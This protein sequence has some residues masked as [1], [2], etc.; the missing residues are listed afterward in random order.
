MPKRDQPE[1]RLQCAVADLL[2]LTAMPGVYW[3]ALPF[4]E[5]RTLE[6]GIRL[7][8]MGVRAGAGDFLILLNGHA[9][10]L[11][12]KVGKGRQNENQRATETDWTV[13]KGTYVVCR[14]F[15]A[16]RGFLEMIEAIRPDRSKVAA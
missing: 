6:T 8:R 5:K 7:K 16:A 13:A 4:G 2:R 12:L 11:E 10:M 9:F 3:S 15:E 14:S 1:F